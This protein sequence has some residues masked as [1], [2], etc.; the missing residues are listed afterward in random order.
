MTDQERIRS[1]F[2]KTKE[3]VNR[4]VAEYGASKEEHLEVR[5]L[6]KLDAINDAQSPKEAVDLS[7]RAITSVHTTLLALLA[8]NRIPG[9]NPAAS[10]ERKA[11]KAESRI[12]MFEKIAASK[13]SSAKEVTQNKKKAEKERVKADELWK[14]AGKERPTEII[15]SDE[16]ME[17]A[18]A[19]I[20]KK[21]SRVRTT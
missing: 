14:K 6:E 10:Y 12:K 3:A 2:L 7:E 21:A 1:I 19:E 9:R 17:E 13:F 8:R 15:L 16:E 4:L 18:E 11:R 5:H 20:T